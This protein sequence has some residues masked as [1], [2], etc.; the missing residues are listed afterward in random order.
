[1]SLTRNTNVGEF[2][3]STAHDFITAKQSKF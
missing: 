1:M 2:I 3:Y